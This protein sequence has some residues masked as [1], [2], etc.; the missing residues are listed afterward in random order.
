MGLMVFTGHRRENQAGR[1]YHSREGRVV[2]EGVAKVRLRN[3]H[4]IKEFCEDNKVFCTFIGIL[5]VLCLV[6]ECWLL[7]GAFTGGTGGHI[8]TGGTVERLETGIDGARERSERITES[9]SN[10]E[11]S[12]NGAAEAVRDGTIAAGKIAAGVDECEKRIDDIKQGFGRI[13]N[14][15][16]DVETANRA[17][18]QDSPAAGVAK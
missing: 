9:V 8:N 4:E 2:H 11:T 12:V 6:C 7:Y 15:I 13:E 3:V 14:I 1:V 10:A 5:F 16:R 18:T 17:R